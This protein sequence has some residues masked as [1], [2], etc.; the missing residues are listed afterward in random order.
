MPNLSVRGCDHGK[1]GNKEDWWVS[2]LA[3]TEDFHPQITNDCFSTLFP[4]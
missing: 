1:E 4:I 3:T 2:G